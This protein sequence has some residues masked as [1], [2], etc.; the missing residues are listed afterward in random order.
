MFVLI[1]VISKNGLP[2]IATVVG[3]VVKINRN[4][5]TNVN[6]LIT[7]PDNTKKIK[8]VD[9]QKKVEDHLYFICDTG[10]QTTLSSYG[11][12]INEGD[13]QQ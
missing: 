4:K 8:K 5:D 12:I 6:I 3:G 1:I 13:K 2:E 10:Y 11:V 9:K 7:Y